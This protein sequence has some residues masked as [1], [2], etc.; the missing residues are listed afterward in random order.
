VIG[1]KSTQSDISTYHETEIIGFGAR[2][3]DL[4]ETPEGRKPAVLLGALRSDRPRPVAQR[5]LPDPDRG[6][7]R[8]GL[9]GGAL[10]CRRQRLTGRPPLATMRGSSEAQCGGQREFRVLY[11]GT[12]IW[13]TA[14]LSRIDI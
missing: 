4:R 9:R 5:E 1:L 8:R 7:A 11:G 3:P 6:S 10:S 13:Q 12:N 14:H 2:L